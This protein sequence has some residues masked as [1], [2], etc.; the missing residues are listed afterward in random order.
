MND[1]ALFLESRASGLGAR[2]LDAV[3]ET[4][5]RIRET[6]VSNPVVADGIRRRRV[7]GFAYDVY[8]RVLTSEVR[9]IVI[10]HHSRDADYWKDRV[11]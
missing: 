1:A 10:F 6:A 11:E 4:F 7:E 3:D 5:E 9:V 2:F 8:Y